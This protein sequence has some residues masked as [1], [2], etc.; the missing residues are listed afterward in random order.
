MTLEDITTMSPKF[1]DFHL[2]AGIP[3]VRDTAAF[4]LL[5]V[6]WN[7]CMGTIASFTR[8]GKRQDLLPLLA[9]LE[10]FEIFGQFMLTEL[11][12]G[13][14]AKNLETQARLQPDGTFVLH[15]PLPAAAKTMPCT[16]PLSGTACVAVVFARLILAG[17]EDAGVR[18]FVVHMRGEGGKMAPGITSRLLPSRP[19]ARPVDNAVTTF[20]HV[21]L[22]QGALLGTLDSPQNKR[23]GFLANIQRVTVGNLA[24]AM[25]NAPV[26]RIAAMITG[27]YSLIRTV[28]DGKPII[29]FGTQHG[30][31]L[32]ALAHAAVFE[33]WGRESAEAFCAAP[34]L[35]TQSAIGAMY[36][37]TVFEFTEPALLELEDRC[38]WQ[39]LYTYNQISELALFLRGMGIGEGAHKVL[40][41]RKPSPPSLC[42]FV[43][44]V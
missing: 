13:L 43:N 23:D 33:A 26:L 20:N 30:P 8:D 32:R 41:I 17:G 14:D 24:V 19:G 7:V 25:P 5:T 22:P 29:T 42:C 44:W 3:W 18:P 38:G 31:I 28:D 34:D 11:G 27:R 35:Q 16:T 36:K 21:H 2:G 15:T 37:A 4:V 12:H 10:R 39:G 9:S 6:H 40:A 1:W